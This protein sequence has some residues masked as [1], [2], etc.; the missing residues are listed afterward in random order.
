M[1]AWLSLDDYGATYAEANR[2]GRESRGVGIAAT[3][4][5]RRDEDLKDVGPVEEDVRV[6]EVGRVVT[7]GVEHER[8]AGVDK[9]CPREMAST[10]SGTFLGGRTSCQRAE[11][12]SDTLSLLYKVHRAPSPPPVRRLRRGGA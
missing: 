6:D 5:R 8:E 10:G 7:F 12:S 2:A 3:S 11:G 1:A 4:S 9:L